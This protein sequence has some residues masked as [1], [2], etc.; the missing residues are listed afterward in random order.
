MNQNIFREYDIRGI[1]GTEL[2]DQT[3]PDIVR[4]IGTVFHRSGCRDVAL[5]WDCR[6]SSAGFADLALVA[7]QE[8]GCSVL[9]VGQVST[10]MLFHTVATKPVEAGVMITGSHNPPD[11]N[12]FKICRGRVSL[13][14][15]QI[16]EIQAIAESKDFELGSGEHSSIEILDEYCQDLTNRLTRLRKGLKVVVDSG[17]GMGGISAVPIYR[18]LGAEVIEL[19]TEPDGNFPNHHPDP[20][21][22]ANL[23][24]LIETVES[25]NADLGIAF[26][27]DGDRIGVVAP[28]GRIVWGD[29]LMI[30]FAR[31]ILRDTPGAKIIGD[32]KCSQTLFDAVADAGGEPVMWKTGHSII[33]A[34]MKETGA[35]LAGEMS[36]HIFFA[37]R[38]YGF[39]DAAYAGGRLLELLA[40]S[41][42]SL[43]EELQDLPTMI[44]TPEIR[45]DCP[46][47]RKFELVREITNW[48]AQ[49]HEVITVDG[50]RI[51]FEHGWG[52]VRAS[53]TQPIIV[54]RFEA[55]T[56]EHLAEIRHE[57]ESVVTDHLPSASYAV[58]ASTV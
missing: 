51:K 39:D 57:V 11:Q 34:K 26:D 35:V 30:L 16:R 40:N 45:V 8:T 29:E 37:D 24:H 17:N 21:V 49:D 6:N 9:S 13:F 18:E 27:G 22:P 23:S 28:N 38:F 31:S 5:G 48:F 36:G 56:A 4:A 44:A 42:R 7:L 52:L 33:K 19:F 25:T 58:A 12:G 43:L 50:V 15:E 14:G 1:V 54:L 2:N 32:V 20:T 53:N 10:P 47:E 41:G 3:V 46:D 55:D